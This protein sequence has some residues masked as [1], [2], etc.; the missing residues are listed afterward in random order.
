[1]PDDAT[2]ILIG[3]CTLVPPLAVLVVADATVV[4]AELFVAEV[5]E[6]KE[7]LNGGAFPS[8]CGLLA[9]APAKVPLVL[10]FPP[11]PV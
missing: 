4:L 2:F 5:A 9:P 8:G 10:P 1:M 3:F 6:A 7:P 11:E